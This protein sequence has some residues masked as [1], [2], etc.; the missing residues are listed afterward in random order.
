M[1]TSVALSFEKYSDH[2]LF[3][4]L[5]QTFITKMC[6]FPVKPEETQ[7]YATYARKKKL[8]KSS[9]YLNDDDIFMSM[10]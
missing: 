2:F 3:S 9:L 10:F 4:F 6:R 8:L 5:L 1:F 7:H